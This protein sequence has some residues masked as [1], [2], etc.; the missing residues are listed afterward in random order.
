MSSIALTL[1]RGATVPR[2]SKPK[3]KKTENHSRSY[4]SSSQTATR[5]RSGRV[6]SGVRGVVVGKYVLLMALYSCDIPVH[7][8]FSAVQYGIVLK[9][10]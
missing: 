5:K 7:M 6:C 1:E 3:I 2:Y 8:A 4:E 9:R 10:P